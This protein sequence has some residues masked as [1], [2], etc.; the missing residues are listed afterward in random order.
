VL[1]THFPTPTAG[2]VTTRDSRRGFWA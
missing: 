1:G 2:Y